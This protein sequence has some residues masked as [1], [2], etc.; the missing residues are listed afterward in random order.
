VLPSEEF[1]RI[2]QREQAYSITQLKEY[3][4]EYDNRL[5]YMEKRNSSPLRQ[6]LHAVVTESKN[7][8]H[9]RDFPIESEE[10][11]KAALE[12]GQK[13]SVKLNYLLDIQRRLESLAKA[14]DR[15]PEKRWQAH[16]DLTLAQT[17]A[18]EVKAYEYRAL[19]AS[20][21]K[22]PPLPKQQ[23]GTDMV[24]TWVVNHSKAPLAPKSE[25]AKKYVEA[26]KLLKEVIARH[27]K[28][29]WAD[30]AQDALDRG[31]SVKFDE[32]HHNPKYY[33]RFQYVPKY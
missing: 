22:S 28:T 32:W 5:T 10:L 6:V 17:V 7:F 27:P 4:P 2:R 3:L 19:M 33:E 8:I 31:L 25:T 9:R 30:L 21:A 11:V 29:P 1:M 26:E 14:R 18:F 23:P 15:E 12:E 24:V 20:I 16:Y 13:A